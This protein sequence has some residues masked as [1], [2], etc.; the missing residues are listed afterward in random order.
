MVYTFE[1]E[2]D[3][4]YTVTTP[5]DTEAQARA[6]LQAYFDEFCSGLKIGRCIACAVGI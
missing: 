2:G 6:M 5:C 4:P 1:V 3:S